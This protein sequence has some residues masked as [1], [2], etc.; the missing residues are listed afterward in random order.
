MKTQVKPKRSAPGHKGSQRQQGVV[1]VIVTIALLAM[2]GAAALAIDINHAFMNRTKLQN[3]VDAAALAAA[4]VLNKSGVDQ[5]RG[6]ECGQPGSKR[7]I[8]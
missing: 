2:L 7:C 1:V 4:V 8:D 6:S 3:G 5:K